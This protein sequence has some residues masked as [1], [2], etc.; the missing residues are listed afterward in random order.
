MRRVTVALLSA[1]V[2]AAPL[3]AASVD[4]L[5]IHSATRGAGATLVFVHGWTCDSSSWAAQVE[6]FAK[7]YRVIALDLPG[8]GQSQSPA[9]GKFSMDLFARAVDEGGRQGGPS[10]SR[11]TRNVLVGA[12]SSGGLFF[13][14]KVGAIDSP[15]FKF[16]V[17]YTWR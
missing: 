5:A 8:H 6:A 1:L 16:G 11:R 15:D 4:G 9:D 12:E 10:G 17:G 7:R 3:R 14:F 2:F 13:E